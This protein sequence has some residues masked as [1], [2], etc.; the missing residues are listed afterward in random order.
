MSVQ[1][2]AGVR[3]ERVEKAL[4]DMTDAE[5]VDAVTSDAPELL[6]LLDELH[7]NLCKV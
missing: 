5:K 7:G 6:T 2:T 4:G 1:G 3:V